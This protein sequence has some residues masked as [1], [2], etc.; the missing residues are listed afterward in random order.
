MPAFKFNDLSSAMTAWEEDRAQLAR[1]GLV[2]ENVVAYLPDEFR[3]NY[4]G[5]IRMALDAQ[6]AMSTAQNSALPTM[7]TSYIDPEVT[8]IIF[9]L[10]KIA[11]IAGEEK[12]G[13]WTMDTALFP[14][15]EHTGETS[16]YDDYA[17]NGSTGAN[18]NWPQRQNFRYQTMQEWGELELERM[19]LSKL[20]WVG[21]QDQACA[22]TMNKYE[23]LGYAFGIAGLQNYGL[24][25]D[26]N[27]PASIT[28]APKAWGGS[29]WVNNGVVVAT[30]NEIFTDIQSLVLQAVNQSGGTV[31]EEDQCKLA[32]APVVKVAMTQTNSFG[33]NVRALLKENFPGLEVVDAVQYGVLNSTNPQ[34]IAAGNLVQLI[35]DRV[36][37]QKTARCAFSEKMRKHKIIQATS[38]WKN[39]VSGALWGTVIKQPFAISSMLGV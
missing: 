6:P 34:G 7:L 17:E 5:A 1:R 20:N 12:K 33:V 30:A 36:E 32:M 13:D 25:N 18:V 19:G 15:V 11:K 2:L 3:H 31:T 8:R 16:A 9:S 39:K 23:N 24:L 35:F 10:N 14:L 4:D 37:G 28:P 22:L 26:P 21:E 38:S 29:K 27:L